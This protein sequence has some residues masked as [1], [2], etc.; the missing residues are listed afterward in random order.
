[1]TDFSE[2]LTRLGNLHDS[3][4]T[5]FEWKPDG[6]SIAF[7]IDDL[8]FNSEGLPEYVGPTPGRIVLRG[9]QH[10]DIEM[11]GVKG[12]LRIYDFCVLDEGPEM[13]TVSITFAPAGKIGIICQGAVFPDIPLP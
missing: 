13:L 3:T 6:K 8:H 9:V 7:E 4:V 1:M 10:I 5:L 2:F 11:R 12:P